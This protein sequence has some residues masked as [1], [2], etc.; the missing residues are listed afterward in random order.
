VLAELSDK[1]E[2]RVTGTNVNNALG[3]TEGNSRLVGA[4]I[5]PINARPIASDGLIHLFFCCT[6]LAGLRSR[7]FCFIFCVQRQG[8]PAPERYADE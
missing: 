6:L 2:F 3:L 4:S 7:F 8:L 1:L 5:G